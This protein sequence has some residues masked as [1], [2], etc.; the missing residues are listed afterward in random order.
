[1]YNSPFT[2]GYRFGTWLEMLDYLI[3]SAEYRFKQ[4]GI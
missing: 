4:G 1:M 3:M 2:H